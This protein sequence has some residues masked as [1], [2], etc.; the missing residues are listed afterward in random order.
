MIAPTYSAHGSRGPSKDILVQWQ[1]A[2]E[3]GNGWPLLLVPCT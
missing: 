1:G 2:G 3:K